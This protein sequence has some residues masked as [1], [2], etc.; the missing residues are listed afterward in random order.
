MD[1]DAVPFGAGWAICGERFR[2]FEQV[3]RP[4]QIDSNVYSNVRFDALS[5]RPGEGHIRTHVRLASYAPAFGKLAVSL[6]HD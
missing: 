1:C 2:R 5:D 3:L 4:R 6:I